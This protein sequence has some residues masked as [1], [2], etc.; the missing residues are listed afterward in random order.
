MVE[1]TTATLRGC[2]V[3]IRDFGFED[4][5]EHPELTVAIS[6]S[7][8]T[9]LLTESALEDIQDAAQQLWGNFQK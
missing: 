7:G 3:D 8:K 4:W 6:A 1:K 9:H 2:Y 5:Q